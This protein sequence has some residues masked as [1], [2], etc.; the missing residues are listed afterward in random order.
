MTV[1]VFLAG[2]LGAA[3]VAL[4]L[5]GLWAMGGPALGWVCPVCPPR[6]AEL[7]AVQRTEL[8]LGL[9]LIGLGGALGTAWLAFL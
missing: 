4:G 9:G 3:A 8:L 5:G 2:P 1:T 6:T 7:A